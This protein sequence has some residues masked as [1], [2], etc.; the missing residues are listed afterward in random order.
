MVKIALASHRFETALGHF[1]I[2]WSEKG[3]ARLTLP[4]PS[5]AEAVSPLGLCSADIRPPPPA[6][7]E[8]VEAISRYGEGEIVDFSFVEIDY[9]Q[10]DE[11]AC[12]IYDAARGLLHGQTATYGELASRA[13]HPGRARETGTA[14]GRNPVPLVVPCHRVLAAGGRLGGFSANG[15]V[16]TKIRLLAHECADTSPRLPGQQ[17]FAF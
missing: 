15:G 6:M 11:F 8:L 12:A 10:A 16:A 14:L 13:G 5:S 3:L 9:G 4:E 7:L 1:A 2:A 17:S